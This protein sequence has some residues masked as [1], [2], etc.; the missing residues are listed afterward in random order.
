MSVILIGATQTV[1]SNLGSAFAGLAATTIVGILVFPIRTF[2]K[3]VRN[4]W[5]A[6]TAKL[7][8]VEKE[9]NIQRTNCLTTLQHQGQSQIDLL[10]KATN[11][12]EAIHLS[13]VEMSGYLKASH[14]RN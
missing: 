8:G 6:A 12:L 3:N 11:T 9:L 4:E 2:F 1:V 13:Q 10:E 5:R 14:D 7:A